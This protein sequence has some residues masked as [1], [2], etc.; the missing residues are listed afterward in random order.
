MSQI[1]PAPHQSDNPE[2]PWYK[3]LQGWK[4]FVEVVA[5]PFAIF[6]AVVTYFQWRDLRQNFRIEQH[7]WIVISHSWPDA[8]QIKEGSSVK[9]TVLITNTG[10]TAAKRI[11]YNFD[12]VIPSSTEAVDFSYSRIH[13]IG[14]AGMVV[15]NGGAPFQMSMMTPTNKEALLTKDEADDLLNGR[16]YLA[17]YGG[18]E[19]R[20]VF[21]ET[22]W[23]HFC[24]WKSY[25]TGS[26]S[27][28][29]SGC[30]E[31]NDAGDDE[32]PETIQA[33]KHQ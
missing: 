14:F 12:I 21:G 5:I 19:F 6:Y 17:I 2:H 7:A 27:V 33:K 28:N 8:N 9:S 13:T 30:T 3:T 23:F 31:Y 18:G 16:R 22:H 20:D 1:P 24:D 29:A 25:Y 15:P 32:A 26:T 4:A 10:K 11:T